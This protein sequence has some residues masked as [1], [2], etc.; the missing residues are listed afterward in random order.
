MS[1][2]KEDL[3]IALCYYGNCGWVPDS[4][5]NR[6]SLS[7]DKCFESVK[8]NIIEPNGNVDIFV[9]SWSW[10]QREEILETMRPVASEIEPQ[11]TFNA[12]EFWKY[13]GSSIADLKSNLAR[14]LR[15]LKYPNLTEDE[16]EFIERAYSRW[17]STKRVIELKKSHEE[18]SDFKYDFVMLLRFDLYW[19]SPVDFSLFN[20]SKLH[21]GD[22]SDLERQRHN[23]L[24]GIRDARYSPKRYREVEMPLMHR[25]RK[26]FDI[27]KTPFWVQP[28][29]R[30]ALLS[31]LGLYHYHLSDTWFFGGNEVMNQFGSLLDRVEQ[32][33][34]N[35]HIAAYQ[36]AVSSVGAENLMFPFEQF[37]D[38]ELYRFSKNCDVQFPRKWM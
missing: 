17:Y 28:G 37:K 34:P 4:H 11:R 22:P 27:P 5:G 3:K 2:S 1:P 31:K 16:K 8:R 24:I 13:R 19:Y 32:H 10:E 15:L 26:R 14:R 21:S 20:Q 36:H 25:L 12:A 35:P 33:H 6:R 23:F 29:F 7:V 30:L 38:F 9:H 18:R